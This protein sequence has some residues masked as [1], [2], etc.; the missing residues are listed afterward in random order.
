MMEICEPISRSDVQCAQIARFY[1][2]VDM[3][4]RLK[5]AGSLAFTVLQTENLEFVFRVN[6]PS[7]IVR[8]I[9]IEVPADKGPIEVVM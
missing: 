6:D 5:T 7:I 8:A 3:D 2:P 9:R 1:D 4:N